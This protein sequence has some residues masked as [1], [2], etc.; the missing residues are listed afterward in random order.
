MAVLSAIAAR[1]NSTLLKILYP[2]VEESPKKL[3]GVP[4]CALIDSGRSPNDIA[5]VATSL[6]EEGFTAIKIKVVPQAP[7]HFVYNL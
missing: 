6:V 4:I 2:K 1:E 7:N 3:L 5:N